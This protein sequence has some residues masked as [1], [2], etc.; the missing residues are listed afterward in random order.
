MIVLLESY[1]F[2]DSA[3]ELSSSW[4]RNFFVEVKRIWAYF[5]IIPSSDGCVNI[6]GN[7]WSRRRARDKVSG[8]MILGVVPESVHSS[9][10]IFI[11]RR[12]SSEG[13]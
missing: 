1:I 7:S 5:A 2:G 6:Q 9:V 12:E 13:T 3:C 11:G 8:V 4:N 10:Y